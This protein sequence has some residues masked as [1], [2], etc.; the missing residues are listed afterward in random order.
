MNR[1]KGLNNAQIGRNTGKNTTPLN[2]GLIRGSILVPYNWTFPIG[3]TDTD[4][5]MV[6][7]LQAALLA[8]LVNPNYNAR[9]FYIGPYE[10]YDDKMEAPTEQKLGYGKTVETNRAVYNDE[11]VFDEG[12]LD[13][14]MS[15][16]SF[17]GKFNQYKRVDIDIAGNVG[18]CTTIDP[19]TGLVTGFQGYTLSRLYPHDRKNANKTT[20]ME[21]RIAY[22]L[23][24]SAEY[25]ENCYILETGVDMIGFVQ[26]LGI[27]DVNITPVG[28]MVAHVAS[29][30]VTA[31]GGGINLA[32]T[33]PA[34]M[35]A[36]SFVFKNGN[37][38]ATVGTTAVAIVG[39]QVQV[40]FDT[41]SGGWS[42]GAPVIMTTT[43]VT[44]LATAG[45]KYYEGV[46]A[47]AQASVVMVA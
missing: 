23:E 12:G 6:T 20:E 16:L 3:P 5:T 38:G 2:P 9:G 44:T 27:Q 17:R 26:N 46:S 43:D 30:V 25:N 28:P 1:V 19:T 39:N 22:T 8:L 42:V 24:N 18:G 13:Y 14:F 41:A 45:F 15:V 34:M 4:A 33:L 32:L 36:A 7:N 11:F 47:A 40:T 10:T 21:Y 31:E 29:Y 37:T 35:V